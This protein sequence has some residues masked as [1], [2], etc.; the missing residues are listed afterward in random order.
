MS[1]VGKKPIAIK[2]GVTVSQEDGRILIRGPLGENRLTLP[3][4]LETEIKDS[5]I[6]LKRLSESKKVKSV[7]G[8]MARLLANA[9]EGVKNGFSKTLEIVGMGYRAQMEGETLTL[10]LGFSH[11][12]KF[13]PPEGIKIEVQENKVKV[14][15]ID[16]EMVGRIADRI[17]KI[18]K[19]DVYKGKGIIYQGEKL[20]LKPG[21]AAAKAG[22]PAGK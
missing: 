5:L 4:G 9:I 19:P 21:K 15:G 18:K 20:K 2:E 3:P 14:S 11:P 1:K 6:Y 17:R 22:V 7:H 13:T 12:V 8:T 16:K 10:Y